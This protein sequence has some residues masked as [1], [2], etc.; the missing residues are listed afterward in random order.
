MYSDKSPA[1]IP[2][3]ADGNSGYWCR[4]LVSACYITIFINLLVLIAVWYF[5]AFGKTGHDP[6]GYW[7]RYILLP[8]SIMLIENLAADMLVRSERVSLAAKEYISVF[9]ML[10]FCTLLCIQHKIVAVLLTSF[11][12]PIMLSALYANIKMTRRTYFGAQVLL[13]LSSL[14]MHTASERDFGFWIWVEMLTA[15]GLLL[16]SYF[17]AKVLIIY[18]KNSISNLNNMR[19]EKMDLEEELRL[20]PLTSLYNRKAYEESLSRFMKECRLANTDLSMAV[21]DI[22]DFKQV[23]DLYGHAAGDKVLLRFA[24]VLRKVVHKGIYAFR[25]GGDEF[26]L[27]FPGFSVHEAVKVCGGILTTMKETTLPELNGRTITLSCG[28]ADMHDGADPAE[29]FKAA[30]AALYSAKQSGKNK[31]ALRNGSAI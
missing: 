23:N 17:L 1:A 19:E 7:M 28:V 13:V 15:S 9:L 5:F 10:A 11:I 6:V 2:D 8:S 21:L 27:L 29:L 25:V 20:D 4:L 3:K 14:W 18:G 31:I 12:L 30:D 22:D 16:A 24:A 26:V